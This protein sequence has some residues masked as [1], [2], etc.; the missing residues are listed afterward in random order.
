MDVFKAVARLK[1]NGCQARVTWIYEVEDEDMQ[2]AGE[3]YAQIFKELPFEYQSYKHV[4]KN[5]LG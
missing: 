4:P 2:E 1:Q 3:T 5:K